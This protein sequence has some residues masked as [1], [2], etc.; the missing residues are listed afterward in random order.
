MLKEEGVGPVDHCDRFYLWLKAIGISSGHRGSVVQCI[1]TRYLHI[2][3]GEIVFELTSFFL[4]L[5]NGYAISW[6]LRWFCI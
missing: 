1:A 6:N 5:K 3:L 2:V 4:Y